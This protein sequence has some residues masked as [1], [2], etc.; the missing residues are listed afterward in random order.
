MGK[1]HKLQISV[2][3]MLFLT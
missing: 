1:F 3:E 2:S